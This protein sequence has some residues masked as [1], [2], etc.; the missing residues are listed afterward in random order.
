MKKLK[1]LFLVCLLG[2]LSTGCVKFNANMDIKKDKSMDFTIVYAVDKSFF[3]DQSSLKEEDFSELKKEGY[4]V[5][6]YKDGNMEG[7]T[8]S[9]KIKNIDEVSSESDVKFDLSGMT[10]STA[11]DR[12][13]FKVV[14]GTDKNTYYAKFSFD[15]N[16]SG[17]SITDDEDLDEDDEGEIDLADEVDTDGANDILGTTSENE[18]DLSS[19]TTNIDLSFNVTLPT[20]AL[21]NNATKAE[22]NNKKLTWSLS[23]S[24]VDSIEFAFELSNSASSNNMMLYIGAGVAVLILI[25]VVIM[26]ASKKKNSGNVEPTTNTEPTSNVESTTNVEPTPNVE[27]TTNTESVENDNTVKQEGN[28]E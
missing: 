3:G 25:I 26:L 14:K 6:K 5:T 2:I 27:P 9:R 12:Y 24:S 13:L 17:L 16:E 28:N 21:S 10:K 11:E 4:S 8:F 15:P 19:L 20:P 18:I 23:S 7:F 22:D 1:Y